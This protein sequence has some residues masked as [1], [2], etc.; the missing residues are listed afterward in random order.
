M[1]QKQKP[2]ANA[3]EWRESRTA[4]RQDELRL[5]DQV[6]ATLR[7][8]GCFS[9][10]AYARSTEG[11]WTFDRS[12]LLSRDVEVRQADET[13]IAVYHEKWTGDGTLE[14]ADGRTYDWAPTNFWQTRWA[15]FDV[16]ERPLIAFEDTSGLLEYRDEVTFWR[17]GLSKADVG[18]LTT[19]GRYLM[20]LKHRDTA[21][22]AATA[23]VAAVT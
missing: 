12:R 23:S 22:I 1:K 21:A 19:L 5:G 13:L 4:K 7:W 8:E 16:E 17:S 2:E 18:L 6:F 3:W 20:V 15:F 9:N 11:Q 10:L 14:F